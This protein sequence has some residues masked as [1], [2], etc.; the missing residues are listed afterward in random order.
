M[1]T[2]LYIDLYGNLWFFEEGVGGREVS[3]QGFSDIF[4]EDAVLML[5]PMDRADT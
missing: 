5:G 1:T 2:G 4:T 3:W